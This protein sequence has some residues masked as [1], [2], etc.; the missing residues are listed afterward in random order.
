MK[1]ACPSVAEEAANSGLPFV[2]IRLVADMVNGSNQNLYYCL[3]PF[4]GPRLHQWMG[5]VLAT[6]L[7]AP[8]RPSRATGNSPCR[9]QSH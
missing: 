3:K 2:G 5:A 7:E 6:L 8:E 4:L 9:M 1:R